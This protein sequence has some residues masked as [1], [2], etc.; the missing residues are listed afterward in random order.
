[1]QNPIFIAL[2]QRIPVGIEKE[3]KRF[4]GQA[5]KDRKEPC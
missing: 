4:I 3:E 5:G 1:V 2:G